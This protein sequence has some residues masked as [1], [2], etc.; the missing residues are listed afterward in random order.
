MRRCGSISRGRT[1]ND[2]VGI[3]L[4]K[5]DGVLLVSDFDDTLFHSGQAVSQKDYEA[6][7]HFIAQGGVFTI[8]TGRAHRTFAPYAN[9]VPINA[10]VVLSNGALLYDFAA[11]QVVLDLPLPDTAA[12]D[13]LQ[14]CQAIPQVGVETYHGDD[15]YIHNP[16]A[17]T[18]RH[19]ERVKTTWTQCDLQDMPTP[20]SKAVIQADHAVL[21]QAQA[22]LQQRWPERYEVIFSNEVLLECTAKT[23]TKGGMV[24][25]LAER[26]GVQRPNIYCV[27]DN[28]NDIPMLAVSAIPFTPANCAP[29]VREWGGKVINSCD[30]SCIAQII[31]ILDERYPPS[32]SAN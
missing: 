4:G 28:Q 31:E 22:F 3:L 26:L 19:V 32:T 27:G 29:A 14:M 25:R 18:Q 2:K 9:I 1:F 15:V 12:A 7:A 13:L 10:P 24:L 17:H 30:D 21:L 20:W 8:A 11:H 5:F 23:A 16:N 6:I